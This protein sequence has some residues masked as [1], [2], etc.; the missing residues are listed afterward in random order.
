MTAIAPAHR[1]VIRA[2]AARDLA[3][4]QE[5]IIGEGTARQAALRATVL[6]RAA[7][8]VDA[9]ADTRAFRML[10]TPDLPEGD[11]VPETWRVQ[12]TVPDKGL[13][14]NLNEVAH[15][16]LASRLE[17]PKPYYRRLLRD[18]PALVAANVNTLMHK[19]ADT[20]L[21]RMMRPVT[22][23]DTHR[24]VA[25]GTTLTLR[26]IL[27]KSYRPL[28]D[29]ELL[30]TVLPVMEAR[31]A[32][33]SEYEVDDRRLHAKF[34]TIASSVQ[35]IRARVMA[36][37][38]LPQ[39]AYT[40]TVINGIDVAWV[41]EVVRAGAYLRNSEV[42][43]SSLQ[44]AALW[45]ILKC[46]NGMIMPATTRVRHVGSRRT[47]EEAALEYLSSATQ[48][49]DAAALMSRVRDS[50]E[51]ALDEQKQI[52]NGGLLLAAKAITVPRPLA[53]PVFEFVGNIANAIGLTEK[54][55]NTMR[56][57]AMN[58]IR[59]EGGETQFAYVQALTATARQMT[60]YDRKAEYETLG[61]TLLE[62]DAGKL[63]KL[64]RE[65]AKE[66]RNN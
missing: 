63:V 49:L 44:V 41:D 50:L 24:A 22:T 65:G 46:L 3:E 57:E 55:A 7:A 62:G 21:F 11:N 42:G 52:A 28:D 13:V 8:K 56:E 64:A 30:A 27:G 40:H 60:D 10:S 45:E 48:T 26:G 17:I 32:Y 36:S 53:A 4:V 66:A 15:D 14:L 59:E 37:H 9:V 6:A 47:S 61:W 23:E 34:L 31:G 1:T 51:A 39:E 54:E 25:T 12:L 29:D 2:N 43:F 18:H 19:E 58:S 16:H 33:L 38:G 35:E 20:R 5:Q